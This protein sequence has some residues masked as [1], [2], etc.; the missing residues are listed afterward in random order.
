MMSKVK[1]KVKI[2]FKENYSKAVE[3]HFG[4]QRDDANYPLERE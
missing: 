2:T 1:K 4:G 3:K